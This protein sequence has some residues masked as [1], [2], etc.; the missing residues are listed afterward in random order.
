[1]TY[2]TRT[3]DVTGMACPMPVVRTRQTI[4][5]LA[6]G[7]VL[8]VVASDRG[9]LSDLPSWAAGCG[10]TL[11]SVQNAGTRFTFLIEKG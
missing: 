8:E 3:L 1:V 7:D 4:D 5:T 9:S 6:T 2:V 11:L 10:H